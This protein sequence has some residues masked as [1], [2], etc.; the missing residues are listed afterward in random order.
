M[1]KD[2]QELEIKLNLS[3]LPAFQLK[4]EALGGQLIEPRQ[5]RLTCVLIHPME[6]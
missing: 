1:G 2:Q 3:D 4:V 5:H 6:N